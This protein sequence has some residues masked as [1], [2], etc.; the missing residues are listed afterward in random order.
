MR[1]NDGREYDVRHP[2]YLAIGEHGRHLVHID[3]ARDD[4]MTILEPLLIATIEYL[5]L[6]A[7]PSSS[8]SGNGSSGSPSS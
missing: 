1:L 2:D 3:P 4:A 7:P 8:D 6:A 5:Q